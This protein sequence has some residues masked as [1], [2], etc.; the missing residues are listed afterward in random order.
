MEK[1]V[2]SSGKDDGKRPKKDKANWKIH[3][4]SKPFSFCSQLQQ[5]VWNGLQASCLDTQKY[6]GF[7]RYFKH[8][9]QY[10]KTILMV[11]NLITLLL[12]RG[13]QYVEFSIEKVVLKVPNHVVCKVV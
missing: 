6:I 12:K 9:H 7:Q 5:H 2:L 1:I 8:S 3:L 11:V 10:L 4:L 13:N